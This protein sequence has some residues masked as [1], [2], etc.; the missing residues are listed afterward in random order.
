MQAERKKLDE[1]MEFYSADP[2]KAPPQLRRAIEANEQAIAQQ[3]Q[4]IE[5]QNSERQRIN[6]AF[7]EE[8]ARLEQLWRERDA[9]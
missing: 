1:E 4:A 9:Q 6:A 2:S 8:L 3:Q 5:G 7:D